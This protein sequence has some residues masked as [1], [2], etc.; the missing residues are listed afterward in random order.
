MDL[1]LRIM[2]LCKSCELKVTSLKPDGKTKA[3]SI[4][5][6]EVYPKSVQSVPT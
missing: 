6:K 4:T 3:F 1:M 2:T 5:Y